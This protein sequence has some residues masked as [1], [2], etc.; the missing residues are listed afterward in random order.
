M[1]STPSIHLPPFSNS[2][3]PLQSPSVEPKTV[4]D[5]GTLLAS[6][7]W[8]E[9]KLSNLP[10]STS[11][12]SSLFSPPPNGAQNK[13]VWFSGAEKAPQPW[14]PSQQ[15]SLTKLGCLARFEVFPYPPSSRTFRPRH[16]ITITHHSAFISLTFYHHHPPPSHYLP[17]DLPKLSTH[18][19]NPNVPL[20]SPLPPPNIALH[21]TLPSDIPYPSSSRIACHQKSI[22]SLAGA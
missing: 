12:K 10:S 4:H 7:P 13:I 3:T 18:D 9:L 14:T 1:F 22:W 16:L 17:Q 21:P 20:F 5:E 19:I 15:P 6:L 8:D 2:C 11:L